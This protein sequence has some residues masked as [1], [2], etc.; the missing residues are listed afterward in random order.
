MWIDRVSAID[1]HVGRTLEGHAF[2][3]DRPT[4]V[5]DRG[6]P[7]YLEEFAPDCADRTIAERRHFAVGLMHPWSPGARTSP[8][9]VGSVTFERGKSGLRF[10]AKLSRTPGG[11]EALELVNDHALGDVSV[12]AKPIRNLTRRIP[13]GV[14]TRRAEIAIRELS[15]APPGMGAHP[16]ALVELV[17]AHGPADWTGL[18]RS[19]ADGT[20]RR[21]ALRARLLLL[22][23]L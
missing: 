10:I 2:L 9:P 7:K 23:P 1:G 11:D 20:P 3:F 12:S 16:G 22:G 4:E 8:V 6:G 5:S 17:R 14:V 21:D 13:R 18:E 15:L 19:P